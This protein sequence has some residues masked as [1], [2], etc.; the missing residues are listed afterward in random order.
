MR[1]LW[2]GCCQTVLFYKKL[3]AE[4]EG[5]GLEFN[6]YKKPC[7]ANRFMNKMRHAVR[8][9]VD[10]IMSNHI[11]PKVNDDFHVWAQSVCENY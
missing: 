11:D 3:K 7:I 2:D 8:F 4:L 10:D 9:H 6:A 1:N 5:I